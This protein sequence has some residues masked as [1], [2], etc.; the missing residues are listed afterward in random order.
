MARTGWCC[1]AGRAGDSWPAPSE[2][3][4]LLARSA[5]LT[6]ATSF[7]RRRLQPR[8]ADLP[9]LRVACS[10]G[11]RCAVAGHRCCSCPCAQHGSRADEME[12]SCLI[13]L[14][15]VLDKL[16]CLLSVSGELG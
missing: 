9:A 2:P 1:N 8:L 16:V 14:D 6:A 7:G 5:T 15:L 13:L 11:P 4:A 10:R 3:A 12:L